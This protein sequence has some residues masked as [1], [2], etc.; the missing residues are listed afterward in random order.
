MTIQEIAKLAGVSS[1]AVSRYFNNGYISEEK[2]EAIDKVVKETGYSPSPS[3]RTLRTKQSKTIGVILPTL[4]SWTMGRIV[5]GIMQILDENGY[6]LLLAHTGKKQDRELEYITMFGR[7]QVDGILLLGTEYTGKH[8][9]RIRASK[10]PIVIV[11][12]NFKGCH[13]IYHDDYQAEY[14]MTKRLIQLG[15]SHIGFIGVTFE[16]PAVG[17]SRYL[18]W[19]DALSAHHHPHCLDYY[20][21]ADFSIQSGYEKMKELYQKYP[22]LDAVVCA[23]DHIAVGALHYLKEQNIPVPERILLTGQGDSELAS[24]I[25]P[26]ITTIHYYYKTSGKLAAEMVLKLIAGEQIPVKSIKLSY[27]ILEKDSTKI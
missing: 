24:V 8:K 9:E 22:N 11:G 3:A 2:R 1:A 5:S 4:D 17:K 13:C 7:Q 20:I 10:V 15:R 12:Q 19:Q 14:E 25:S 23:T 26:S 6:Q 18:G 27:E 21:L 16:D